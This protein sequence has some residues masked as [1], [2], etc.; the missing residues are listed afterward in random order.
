MHK[1]NNPSILIK[2]VIF[3]GKK[4]DIFLKKGIIEKIG[5]NLNYKSDS[6]IDCRGT[7]AA[8][9]PM[10]NSHTHSAMSLLRGIGDD[11]PLKEWLERNIWPIEELMSPDDVYWGTK[12]ACL[13]MIKSGTIFFN[14]MYMFPEV[15]MK[16]AKEAGMKALI[17]L[18]MIDV[19]PAKDKKYVENKY[20]EIS[21]E[22]TDLVRLSIAPHAIY[23]VCK[24]SFEWAVKFAAK[25]KMILHTH[26]SETR[27]EVVDSKKKY[28]VSP[29]EFLDNTG[30]LSQKT[31]LAHG[32]WLSDADIKILSKKK[33][34]L[35]YNPSSNMKLAVGKNFPYNK[36]KV[37]GIN[38]ALGTDGSAS[39]NSLDMIREMKIGSLLQKHEEKDSTA[40]PAQEIL[41]C[42]TTNGSLAFGLNSGS[43]KEG[44]SADIALI[45]LNHPSMIPGFN[46]DSDLVYSASG[47][48]IS[49]L[50][51]AGK[52][53]MSDG[54]VENENKIISEFRKRASFLKKK[55]KKVKN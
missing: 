39:N 7:K 51:C 49:D 54:K 34:T 28:G 52:I 24:D 26:I 11:I 32:V 23:T 16:A 38:I 21:S 18:V 33:C 8:I 9:S 6:M 19:P 43:V 15:V 50:I 55:S 10:I 1:K 29:V 17:G 48:V 5:E 3:E 31:V 47:S 20:R 41:K 46:Q 37:A 44:R 42:A 25:N 27:D 45:N 40:C 13:E 22:Q 14:E 2:N 4:K 53:I 36:A 35:V 30:F 12:F